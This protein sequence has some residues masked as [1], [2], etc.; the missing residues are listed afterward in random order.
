MCSRSSTALPSSVPRDQ[1]LLPP[2]PG[3]EEPT[4]PQSS[5]TVRDSAARAELL[6]Q[7]NFP[8]PH[9]IPDMLTEVMNCI[10]LV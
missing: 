9:A 7:R 3:S 6:S 4:L 10:S 2:A 8:S 5:P 1:A